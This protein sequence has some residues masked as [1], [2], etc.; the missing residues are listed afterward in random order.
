M[1]VEFSGIGVTSAD[2]GVHDAWPADAPVVHVRGLA[3]KGTV[4]IRTMPHDTS[5]TH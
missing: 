3:Y 4:E 1:R 5:P 2:D